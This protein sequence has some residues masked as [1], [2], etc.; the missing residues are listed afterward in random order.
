MRY[1][2]TIGER[3]LVVELGPEGARVDGR[4]MAASLEHADGS[5]VRGLIVDGRSHRQA[6]PWPLEAAS[7]R[8]RGGGGRGR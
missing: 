2:V 3:V 8:R 6:R 4:P 5:P 1:Y 7:A